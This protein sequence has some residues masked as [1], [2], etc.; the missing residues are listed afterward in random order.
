M[1]KDASRN[2]WNDVSNHQGVRAPLIGNHWFIR[3]EQLRKSWKFLSLLWR[4]GARWL[5]ARPSVD[6]GAPNIQYIT[7]NT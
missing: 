1:K 6:V 3:W 2:R 4:A 5:G 7:F